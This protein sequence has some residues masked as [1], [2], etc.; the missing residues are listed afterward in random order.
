[1]D[2]ND[3]LQKAFALNGQFWREGKRKAGRR[4]L[5]MDLTIGVTG[6]FLLS[7]SQAEQHDWALSFFT[8]C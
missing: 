2:K 5:G 8:N 4:S 1:M 6:W 3:R 7:L